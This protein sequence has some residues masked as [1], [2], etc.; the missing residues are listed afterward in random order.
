M[1]C[2]PSSIAGVD[3]LAAVYAKQSLRRTSD[4]FLIASVYGYTRL[5]IS[6]KA[7]C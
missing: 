5:I 3:Y 2:E 1:S 4:V 6:L 7:T